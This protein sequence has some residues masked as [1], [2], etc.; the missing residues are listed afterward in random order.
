MDKKQ[1]IV[2]IAL[3]IEQDILRKKEDILCRKQVYT[4]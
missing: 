3:K 2:F 4:V 1:K